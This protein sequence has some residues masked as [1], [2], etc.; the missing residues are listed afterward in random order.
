[1][2]DAG[3]TSDAD[4]IAAHASGESRPDESHADGSRANES[5]PDESHADRPGAGESHG[6]KSRAEASDG[7]GQDGPDASDRSDDGLVSRLN[8]I[9]SQPLSARAEAFARIHDEL[10]AQLETDER[11]E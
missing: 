5:H 2:E 1:M 11:A 7:A 4:A 10:L 3:D 9:E 8:V 6:D